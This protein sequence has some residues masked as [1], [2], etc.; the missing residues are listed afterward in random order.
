[1]Y[2][3]LLCKL[4]PRA[5]FFDSWIWLVIRSCF[6]PLHGSDRVRV[7][8]WAIPKFNVLCGSIWLSCDV[9]CYNLYS[10]QNRLTCSWFRTCSRMI[11]GWSGWQQNIIVPDTTF[12]WLRRAIWKVKVGYDPKAGAHIIASMQWQKTATGNQSDSTVKKHC[13]WWQL[14]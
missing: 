12:L 7:I 14:T 1:M 3:V 13:P 2:G 9:L 10:E 8:F 11:I 4:S 5:E 6:R